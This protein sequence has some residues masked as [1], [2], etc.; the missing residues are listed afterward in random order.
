MV[1]EWFFLWL[2]IFIRIRVQSDLVESFAVRSFSISECLKPNKIV[3]D[4]LTLSMDLM[5]IVYEVDGIEKQ[6]EIARQSHETTCRPT[7]E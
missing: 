4:F 3:Q 5:S 6:T 7:N 1:F 2:I